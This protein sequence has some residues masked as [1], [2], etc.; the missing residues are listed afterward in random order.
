MGLW[1]GCLAGG[2][3]GKPGLSRF[4]VVFHQE[5]SLECVGSRSPSTLFPTWSGIGCLAG[6]PSGKPGLSRFVFHLTYLQH[7]C[8]VSDPVRHPFCL[9]LCWQGWTDL[10]ASLACV[11]YLCFVVLKN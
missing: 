1:I 3:S 4:V 10:L 6:E 5:R 11:S 7:P 9:R 8:A 2:P